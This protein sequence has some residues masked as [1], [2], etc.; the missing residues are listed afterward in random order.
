M[1]ESLGELIKH[2]YSTSLLPHPLEILIQYVCSR[3]WEYELKTTKQNQ[4]TETYEG[5]LHAAWF[6]ILYHVICCQ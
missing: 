2:K 6:E 4:Y 1:L 5:I 3:L